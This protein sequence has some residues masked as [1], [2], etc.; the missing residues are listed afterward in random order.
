VLVP[1]TD[2]T[3]TKTLFRTIQSG[4]YIR[5]VRPVAGAGRHADKMT[6]V[7][8][9]AQRCSANGDRVSANGAALE[10]RSRGDRHFRQISSTCASDR[11][12]SEA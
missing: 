5:R 8:P 10:E 7:I 11:R 3:H 9:V 6:S 2:T 4:Q 12:R 1:E